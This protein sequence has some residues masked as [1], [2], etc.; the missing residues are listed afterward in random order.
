MLDDSRIPPILPAL[1][2]LTLKRCRVQGKHCFR[3]VKWRVPSS[4]P[5]LSIGTRPSSTTALA[6]VRFED[7]PGISNR[8]WNQI[9]EIVDSSKTLNTV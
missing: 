5:T 9:L 1:T 3:W 4:D 7:C 6:Q 8:E 2:D